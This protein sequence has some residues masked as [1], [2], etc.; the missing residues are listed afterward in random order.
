[1]L[2]N[3]DGYISKFFKYNYGVST[4]KQTLSTRDFSAPHSLVRIQV[5]PLYSIELFS[6]SRQGIGIVNVFGSVVTKE[7]CSHK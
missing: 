1:M 5:N 7:D 3:S 6:I 4:I 2:Q